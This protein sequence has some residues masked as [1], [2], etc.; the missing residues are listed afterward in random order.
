MCLYPLL[1]SCRYKCQPCPSHTVH[2]CECSRDRAPVPPHVGQM[3]C[4]VTLI[5]L[6][7]PV[8]ASSSVSCSGMVIDGALGLLGGFQWNSKAPPG[9]DTYMSKG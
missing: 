8:N 3:R 4:R 2:V 6:V 7:T 1:C 9:S 5:S